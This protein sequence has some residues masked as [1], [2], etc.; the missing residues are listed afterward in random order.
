M[1][2]RHD[3]VKNQKYS[4]AAENMFLLLS[5]G[6]SP[7]VRSLNSSEPHFAFVLVLSFS[8][9]TVSYLQGI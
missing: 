3:S 9:G 2:Y 4:L 6:D 1:A 7:W 5:F 8:F